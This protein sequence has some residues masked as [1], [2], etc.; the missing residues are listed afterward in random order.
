M[1]VMTLSK[2]VLTVKEVAAVLRVHPSS[3]Y[4]MLKAGLLPAFRVGSD[5]RCRA[6][7]LGAWLAKAQGSVWK[8]R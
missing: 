1:R 6:V 5:W 2:D 8:A 7:D 3:V 4:R